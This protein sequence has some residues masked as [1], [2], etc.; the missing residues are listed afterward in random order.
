VGG[1]LLQS[2]VI[3]VVCR[4][5]CLTGET[6]SARFGVCWCGPVAAAVFVLSFLLGRGSPSAQGGHFFRVGAAATSGTF[7]EIGAVIASAISKPASSQ[8]CARGGSGGGA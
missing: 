7:F 1:A 6:M 3:H 4:N 8:H 2:S 5:C